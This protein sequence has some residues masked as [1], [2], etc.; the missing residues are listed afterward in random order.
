MNRIHRSVFSART[1]TCVA[2][3][4]TARAQGKS[5]VVAGALLSSVLLSGGAAAQLAPGALP[6]GGEVSAGQASISS[7]GGAMTINQASDRA[8]INWQAFNIGA[9]ASVQFNQ[10]GATS[11]A[12]NRVVGNEASVI[13]GALRAN[14]QVWLVNP[15]GVLFNRSARVDV[16]GLVAATRDISLT[17]FMAGRGSFQGQSAGEVI[18]HGS[19]NAAD[20]GYVVLIG[21]AVKN[22]GTVTARLGSI[23]AAAGDKVTL[24]FGGNS[25]VGVAIDEGALNALVTNGGAMRADGGQIVLTAKTASALLDAVVNNTGE[26]RAQTIANRQGRILLLSDMQNGRVDVGGMLDASAANG[27]DG[28]F[29]ETSAADVR[30]HAGTVV[31]TAA[32]WGAAGTWLIDPT[33]F[34]IG[35]GTTAQTSAGIG[36]STL[37]SALAAGNVTIQTQSAGSGN[38]DINVDAALSWSANKLTLEAHGDININAVMTASG[39]SQLDLKTGYNFNTSSPSYAA[40]NTVRMGFS[41]NGSF[42]GR[43]DFTS[44]TRPSGY[45]AGTGILTINGLGYTLLDSLGTQGSTGT[46]ELTSMAADVSGAYALAGNINAS[47]TANWTFA[48]FS[49][50]WRPIGTQTLSGCCFSYQA[51]GTFSGRLNGLGHSINGLTTSD[52]GGYNEL[53]GLNAGLFST[54]GGGAHV[55][56]L[57]MVDVAISGFGGNAT[58]AGALA[59]GAGSARVDN[60]SVSGTVQSGGG[61]FTGGLFGN[62]TGDVRVSRAHVSAA[63]SGNNVGGFMGAIQFEAPNT[64]TAINDS[65]FTGSVNAARAGGVVGFAGMLQGL[66][67][68]QVLVTGSLTGSVAADPLRATTA[69]LPQLF[70]LN[71]FFWN[72]QIIVSN[73]TSGSPLSTAELSDIASYQ[74][75]GFSIVGNPLLQ[76]GQA[77]LGSGRAGEVWQIYQAAVP[78]SATPSSGQSRTEESSLPKSGDALRMVSAPT[79]PQSLLVSSSQRALSVPSPTPNALASPSVSGTWFNPGEPLSLIATLSGSE[80]N[81][82]VSLTQ[83]RGLLNVGEGEAADDVRVPVGRN[84]LAEIVNGGVRLPGGVDQ[85]LFLVKP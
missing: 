27:G 8:A 57:A 20:G 50:G 40:A 9:N 16:G 78:V 55:S 10:P 23:A 19:I 38:G 24:N 39:T 51:S 36:A 47:A 56:N 44:S 71:G 76:P 59:G 84:T 3:A 62:V 29:I 66:Q 6:S 65:V 2:V 32:P 43:I 73:S 45:R 34:T 42:A 58:N 15:N 41:P 35:A 81:L 69:S 33:D 75:N 5:N 1:G 52:A 64:V 72:S 14:G 54:L 13:D 17:D 68:N 18:N 30:V 11:I 85:L 53:F 82:G 22:E 83:A 12:L 79:L 74:P 28:G 21:R 77:V 25:L 80:P 61:N 31:S 48:G 63:V 49:T 7:M 37:A 70:A 4:E 60:V 26:L 46:G 67:V